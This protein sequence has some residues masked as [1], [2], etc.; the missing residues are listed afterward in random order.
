M[1]SG[2]RSTV[3]RG[4]RRFWRLSSRISMARRLIGYANSLAEWIAPEWFEAERE[5]ANPKR[6]DND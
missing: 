5:T 1:N 4:W 2:N 3:P 6:K